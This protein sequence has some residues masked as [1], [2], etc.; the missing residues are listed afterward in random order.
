MVTEVEKRN[1]LTTNASGRF[2][3]STTAAYAQLLHT[4][5]LFIASS[6]NPPIHTLM[7]KNERFHKMYYTLIFLQGSFI[8]VNPTY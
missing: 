7:N 6:I 2:S 1:F 5:V 3:G 4:N 8:M